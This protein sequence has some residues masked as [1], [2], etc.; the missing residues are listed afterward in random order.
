MITNIT[1]HKGSQLHIFAYSTV[2][3]REYHSFIFS[4]QLA[5]EHILSSKGDNAMDQ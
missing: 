5:T 2:N 3:I 1:W 4:I